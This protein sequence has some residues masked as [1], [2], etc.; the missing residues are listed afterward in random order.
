M[1]ENFSTSD[2]S[3]ATLGAASQQTTRLGVAIVGLGGAVATTAVAGVALLRAGAMGTT[4]L[5]LATL[6]AQ[7][8]DQ[9]VRYENLVFGGWDLSPDDLATAARQHGVLE[10][11][12]MAD[13]EDEL[14]AI[15]P[16]P[17]VGNVR[18]CRNVTG[19]HLLKVESHAAAVEAIR[20]NLQRFREEQ[21][22]ERVVV[23]NL[24]STEAMPDLSLP[25]FATPEAFEAAVQ[26][27]DAQIPP[28]MLYAYAAILEDVPYVNF[29]PSCAADAPALLRLAEQRGVPVS[30]KD[31]K[32]GQTF[33][34]TVLAPALHARNLHIDGWF[35][36][37]IL[38]NR[39][40]LALDNAESLASKITTKGSVLDQITGYK[41]DNHVVHIHYY[42]PRGDNKEA[43]DNIDVEG[44]L[45]QK[46]QIKINF[47][48]RD[49][50]LAAPLALELARLADLAKRRN[51]GGVT[52]ALGVFFKS[53]MV[54]HPN[55]VPIHGFEQQ[56]AVLLN[57]LA[58][59]VEG[60]QPQPV[61]EAAK[62]ALAPALASF[63]PDIPAA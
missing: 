56:Q 38:G 29:T 23:I 54:A 25:Q 44:F 48:C 52:P 5:P 47:L 22:L 50:I 32:T 43:W 57:W 30:G 55:E 21:D 14:K 39:D 19:Q 62:G 35:S 24:A 40:G 4:G 3:A 42:K 16:W 60:P 9:L 63:S 58:A 17:A 12:Q 20:A 26:A 18:F 8:T 27:D 31:G 41:V 59:G 2:F 6:P 13:V 7:L 51:E 11:H 28:A 1:S 15:Q 33:M 10:R 34:K 37:N 45:G 36:T 61:V 46:M 53:P 49:S